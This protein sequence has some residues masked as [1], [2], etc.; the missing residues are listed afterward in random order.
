[1]KRFLILVVFW[2][3]ACASNKSV[4][5]SDNARDELKNTQNL[6]IAELKM[7][8]LD[9]LFAISDDSL[10]QEIIIKEGDTFWEFCHENWKFLEK[11]NKIKSE[12]LRIGMTVRVPKNC[13]IAK[14]YSPFPKFIKE[15]DTLN[16]FVL[17][18]LENQFMAGYEKGAQKFW[19]PISS[20]LNTLQT[21]R[22]YRKKDAERWGYQFGKEYKTP[23]GFF[24][25]GWKYEIH[26]SSI[27]EEVEMPFSVLFTI[28][29]GI[30][31]FFHAGKIYGF[32]ASHGCVR[33]FEEDAKFF[34]DWVK[35][36]TVVLI[37]NSKKDMAEKIKTFPDFLKNETSNP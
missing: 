4:I 37:T 22:W 33:M 35:P 27:Y 14:T 30:M 11:I 26:S 7:S 9:S 19:K 36:K 12:Y 31:Y 3:I 15:I 34:F 21:P 16:Q 8:E 5:L 17:V 2:L 13:D 18:D 32:P 24:R 1:M 28:K 20:G 23:E 6:K 10:F 25:I 29:N